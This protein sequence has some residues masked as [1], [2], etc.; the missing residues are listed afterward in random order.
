VSGIMASLLLDRMALTLGGLL[1]LV[2]VAV[3]ASF[4]PTILFALAG[5]LAAWV[6][7]HRHLAGRRKVDPAATMVERAAQLSRLF[8]A[9]F[10]VMGHTHVPAERPAGDATYINLGSW[11]EEEPVE[12]ASPMETP[13]RAARTHVVIHVDDAGA[14]AHLRTWDAVAGVARGAPQLPDT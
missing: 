5:V 3:A 13:T 6:L 12:G 2:A 4:Y 11:A 7:V 10:V 14:K 9:A 1:A 8:P